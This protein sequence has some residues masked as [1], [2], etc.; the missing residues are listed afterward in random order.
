MPFRLF[1]RSHAPVAGPPQQP[2]P[3]PRPAGARIEALTETSRVVGYVRTEGRLLD[4]LNRRAPFPVDLAAS[5]PLD[6]PGEPVADPSVRELD[7]YELVAVLVGADSELDTDPARHAAVRIRRVSY[8]VRLD[9]DVITI[10]GVVHMHP[11]TEPSR[12]RD[13]RSELFIPITDAVVWRGDRELGGAW[14]EA[15]LANRA[16]LR[17]VAAAELPTDAG[18]PPAGSSNAA[19][20]D[21]LPGSGS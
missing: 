8:G 1:S 9:F 2:V 21:D 10:V 19:G 14:V 20:T 7:P 16:Y 6:D 4:L 12:L 5:A 18:W 17:D 15:V 11:G 13:L 3:V